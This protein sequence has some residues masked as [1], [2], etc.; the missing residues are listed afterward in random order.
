[1]DPG[2]ILIFYSDGI[3]EASDASE[4]QFDIS[5]LRDVVLASRD[6]PAKTI[7]EDV[8]QAVREFCDGVPFD[9]DATLVIVK[10]LSNGET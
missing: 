7:V 2:D 5:R 6:R 3:V 4:E 1:M 9:D 8:Y 10:V